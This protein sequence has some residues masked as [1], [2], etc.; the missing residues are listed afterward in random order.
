VSKAIEARRRERQ[1]YCA[2]DPSQMTDENWSEHIHAAGL[3]RDLFSDLSETRVTYDKIEH[4]VELTR[5]IIEHRPENLR[6]IADLLVMT[7]DRN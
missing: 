5:W 4:G 7:L 6:E 3:L 1:Y 2:A